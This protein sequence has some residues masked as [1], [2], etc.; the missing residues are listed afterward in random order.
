CHGSILLHSRRRACVDVGGNRKPSGI[1]LG[2]VQMVGHAVDVLAL[3][4][5]QDSGRISR[6]FGHS[7]GGNGYIGKV[8]SFYHGLGSGGRIA[9]NSCVLETSSSSR[10]LTGAQMVALIPP[11]MVGKRLASMLM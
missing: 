1:R 11:R 4:G 8:R 3:P 2:C 10:S 9:T 7:H 5:V 6:R